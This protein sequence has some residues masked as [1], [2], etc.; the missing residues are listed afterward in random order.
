[1]YHMKVRSVLLIKVRTPLNSIINY[2][3][4]A[5]EERELDPELRAALSE[6]H[7]AGKALIF[8]INDLLVII[9]LLIFRI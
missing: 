9:C 3:E 1:M 7:K 2:L 4:A 6:S 5:L 8:I